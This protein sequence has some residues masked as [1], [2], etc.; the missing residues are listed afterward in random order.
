MNYRTYA[1]FLPAG[2]LDGVRAPASTWWRWRDHRVHVARAVVPTAAVR[3]LVI[4]GGGGYSGALWPFAAVAAGQAVDVLAPDL[5]LYGDTE[6]ADPA[7]V[8]YGDWVDLLAD[9]VRAERAADPRPLIA[10]GASMGGM[11]AYEIAARTGAVDAVVATCLLDMADPA[12]RAAATRYAWLGRPAPAVLNAAEPLFGRVRIPIRWVAD[13]NKMSRDRRL[14]RLCA[15]D[16]RGGGVSVPLGF[17]S[18]WMAF[19]H[20]R[21]EHYTGAPVTLVAPAA[22][23]WTPPELSIGFLQRITARAEVVLLERCGHFPIEEP[24]LTQLRDAMATVLSRV[25][26]PTD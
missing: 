14:S 1:E 21:P 12:A 17:L 22:D 10:F 15:S 19:V 26:A 2:Y 23:A 6:V 16:P 20:T 24:G 7:G 5:P 4:H 3:V 11:L 9:L 13:M 18:S 25:G 8:R